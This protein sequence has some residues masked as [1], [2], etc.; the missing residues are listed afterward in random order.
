MTRNRTLPVGAVV[1]AAAWLGGCAA[2]S[3]TLTNESGRDLEYRLGRKNHTAFGTSYGWSWE[4]P[5]MLP[6]AQTVCVLTSN[7][8][9]NKYYPYE[10]VSI[11]TAPPGAV[12]RTVLLQINGTV[13]L[14]L[15]VD[16]G[17]QVVVLN[18]V[19]R[20]SS[21]FGSYLVDPKETPSSTP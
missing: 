18:D 12:E 14:R 20:S 19:P 17:G 8:D 3:V 1:G 11:S 2:S 10:M 5:L 15:G 4:R 6:A 7:L 9:T 16:E 13:T 21:L